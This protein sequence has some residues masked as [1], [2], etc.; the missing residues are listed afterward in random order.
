MG[1]IFILFTL[2]E[3]LILWILISK[4]YYLNLNWYFVGIM[5]IISP[6]ILTGNGINLVLRISI[7]ALF[8]LM[9]WS[10]EAIMRPGQVFRE[11][12]IA[13]L[14]IGA[15]TPLFEI[16]RSIY[17]TYEFF[18]KP[19]EFSNKTT[20]NLND[21]VR[22]LLAPEL[23]HPNALIADSFISLELLKPEQATNFVANIKNSVLEKYLIKEF[24]GNDS[25]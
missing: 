23:D 6:F 22:F 5:L 4:K 24:S 21:E 25:D 15:I 17:R 16:N 7:P 10:I 12:I 20:Q 9:I 14:I 11:L 2:L 1:L 19:N 13:V 8:L 3:W 18:T